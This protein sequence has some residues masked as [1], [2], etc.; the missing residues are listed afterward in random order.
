MPKYSNLQYFYNLLNCDNVET[1]GFQDNKKNNY[2]I[3]MDGVGLYKTLPPNK[4]AKNLLGKI[5]NVNWGTFTGLFAIFKI[6]MDDPE[7]PRMH[8][9][10][11]PQEFVKKWNER[12]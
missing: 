12:M 5:K 6:D 1:L 2:V 10:I 8:M 11:T 3:I 4:C 7:Q 9:D